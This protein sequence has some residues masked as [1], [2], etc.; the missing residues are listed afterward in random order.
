ML[1]RL[2]VGALTVAIGSAGA[3]LAAKPQLQEPFDVL[4]LDGHRALVADRSAN[5]VLL[6]DLRRRTGRVLVR[7]AAP[8]AFARLPDGRI[9]VASGRDVVALHPGTARTQ[10]L[11]RAADVVL[12]VAVAAD[13]TIYAS[14]GGTAIVRRRGTVAREVVA[15]GFDGV[16]GMLATRDGIILAEAFAGRVLLLQASGRPRVLARNLGN[17]SYVARGEN[18]TLYLT[19]FAASRVSR[20]ERDGT[21]RRVADVSSPA[22]ITVSPDGSLLVTTLAGSLVRIA[23]GGATRTAYP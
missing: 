7:L 6:L 15:R 5:A 3:A 9:A 17:P 10:R 23:P 12:G 14:E 22:G 13:G 1:L 18:G 11:L 4:A 8:R 2:S 16:H 20:L 21:V 19:E